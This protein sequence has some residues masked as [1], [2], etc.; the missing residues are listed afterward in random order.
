M[1][2]S[3]N[4]L[5]RL[6]WYSVWAWIINSDWRKQATN[7]Y[8]DDKQKKRKKKNP[9]AKQLSLDKEPYWFS[10]NPAKVGL[11]SESFSFS[12]KSQ[13]KGAKSL[14]WASSLYSWLRNKR[15]STFIIFSG[16]TSNIKRIFG[17]FYFGYV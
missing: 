15:I 10:S 7:Q 3:R 6:S 2:F 1:R 11:I 17:F 5:A 16:A 9:T 12:L 13:K 4:S 14:T 8:K